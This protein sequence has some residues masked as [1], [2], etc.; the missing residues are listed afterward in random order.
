MSTRIIA[1]EVRY[2]IQ[3]SGQSWTYLRYPPESPVLSITGLQRGKTYDGE[4]RSLGENGSASAWA[5]V[6]WVVS[7]TNREGAAALPPVTSANVS[8]RWV[9]GTEID[10][11]ATDTEAT[12]NVSA[13]VL[14]VGEDQYSY[15]AS[16]VEISGTAEEVKTVYLYYDDP[17]LQGGSRTLGYTT[18]SVASMAGNGRI[19]IDQVTI[20]FDASGG[21]GTSGGGDIG[22]GG[23]G[24]GPTCPS[25]DAWLLRRDADGVVEPIQWKDARDGDMAM[26]EDGRFGRLSD[27]RRSKVARVRVVLADGHSLTCSRTAPLRRDRG[28]T[29]LA[30]ATPGTKLAY[31]SRGDRTA[32]LV[33]RVEDVGPGWV[34]RFTCGKA[35]VWTGDDPDH[36]LAHHNLKPD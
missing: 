25:E 3:N 10:W 20:A 19:L 14:Q 5:P 18:D 24:S 21:T 23:G 36:L 8:S 34:V 32:A 13:G 16:S 6:S 27:L 15:N 35:F 4:A 33:S 1:Y 29:L 12:V 7:D 22:G 28:G 11:S 31:L 9:S 26:L 17:F 30:P 2:R